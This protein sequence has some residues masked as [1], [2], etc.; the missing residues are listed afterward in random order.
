MNPPG[1]HGNGNYP[2]PPAN[3]GQP[4]N[5]NQPQA[6]YGQQPGYGQPPPGGFGA[7]SP[8]PGVMQPAFGATGGTSRPTTR[9]AFV[10]GVLPLI[11]A[12]FGTVVCVGLS[13]LLD[14]GVFVF[15][16][17]LV[18]L[19]CTIW[20]LISMMKGLRELRSAAN[21]LAFPRWPVFMP[22]YNIIYWVTMVPA[23]V[24]RAK[25]LR[26]LPPTTSHVALYF[27]FP[28]LALQSDLNDLARAQ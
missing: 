12:F 1:G 4:P 2:P 6:G 18:Q 7:M 8:G 22:V 11:I 21:N 24:K 15:L 27:L 10:V 16:A 14:A 25:Q 28:V 17:Q 19:G 9:N 13:A 20:F 23:E 26:G 3:P 5:Y